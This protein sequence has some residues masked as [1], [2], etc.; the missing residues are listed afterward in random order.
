MVTYCYGRKTWSVQVSSTRK[1]ESEEDNIKCKKSTNKTKIFK[2]HFILCDWTTIRTRQ[3]HKAV[4]CWVDNLQT[5]KK[6][7]NSIHDDIFYLLVSDACVSCA[8]FTRCQP[9][10]KAALHSLAPAL[11]RAAPR[12]QVPAIAGWSTEHIWTDLMTHIMWS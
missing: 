8:P 5:I 9:G 6:N 12:K 10:T 1:T 4:L 3:D 7:I 11:A 2:S